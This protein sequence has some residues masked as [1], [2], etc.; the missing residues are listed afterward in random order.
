MLLR[1][2]MAQQWYKSYIEITLICKIGTRTKYKRRCLMSSVALT[3]VCLTG[4]DMI[5]THGWLYADIQTDRKEY[6]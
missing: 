6:I 1:N 3:V 4:N 5:A 2:Q